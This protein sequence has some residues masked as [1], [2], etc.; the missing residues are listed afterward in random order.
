MKNM[1]LLLALLFLGLLAHAQT[2][3]SVTATADNTIYQSPNTSSNA[4]GQNMLCGT[5][6]G[7]SPRRG[8]IRF[9]LASLIPPGALI[10]S[11]TLTLHCNQS[12]TVPDNVAISKLSN[13]WGEGT[14]NAGSL[15]DGGGVPATPN[16]ATWLTRYF[17]DVAWATAGGEYE[18]AASASVLI[19][20]VGF[21]QWSGA[22]VVTDVQSW[23][24]DPS[25]NFGWVLICNE[26]AVGTARKFGSKENATLA[27]RPS[28]SVTY[29]TVVPVELTYFKVQA[30]NNIGYLEWETS[31]ETNNRFF[32]MM[33]SNNGLN[34]SS[35]GRINGR[36]NSTTTQHYKF[37]HHYLSPGYHFYK[38]MQVDIGGRQRFSAIE[39]IYS[40]PAVAVFSNPVNKAIQIQAAE[41]LKGMRYRIFNAVGQ[42]VL[43][44]ILLNATI[45][46]HALKPGI[47]YLRLFHHNG[48]LTQTSFLK[49]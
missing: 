35:I 18:A 13:S 33:H 6:G 16:D 39:K 25:G 4:L 3:V 38:L 20:S 12:R 29:T 49:L 27:N 36:T 1:S 30:K 44:G 10:T 41:N 47:Y 34:F 31:S 8:L 46:T 9:D 17:P 14:S 32:E 7:G 45:E 28:L 15:G 42:I 43:E 2:T 48:L 5:N 37:T 19:G 11:A 21:Y 40:H 23:I 22:G 26:A 24:N